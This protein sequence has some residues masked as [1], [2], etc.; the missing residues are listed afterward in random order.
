MYFWHI[1]ALKTEL[2]RQPLTEKQ[3]LPYLV[4][5]SA[6]T[7]AVGIIPFGAINKWD[8]L[9]GGWS[10]L[11]AIV[12]TIYVYRQNGGE[13]GHHLLQ[14]YLSIGWVVGV[15]WIAALMVI[16][17]V[18]FS[19]LEVLSEVSESTTWQDFVLLAVAEFALYWR[20]GHH[21]FEVANGASRSDKSLEAARG[22]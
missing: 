7:A 4:V 8:M 6:L 9:G 14:R 22:E 20:I 15:R 16:A 5:F 11:L 2:V 13:H 19:L 10:M 3:V 18:Y 12:G 21:I 17:V 1:E